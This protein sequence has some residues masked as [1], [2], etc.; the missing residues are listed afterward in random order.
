MKYFTNISTLEQA[1]K[2]YRL[3]AKKYHPDM[4][5]T[6]IEF[7]EMN[8]EYQ[9]LLI[10]LHQKSEAKVNKQNANIQNNDFMNELGRIAKVLVERQVPQ[11]YLKQRIN[12]TNSK[13]KKGILEG[14]VSF[15]NTL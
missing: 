9:K 7:H 11:T 14:I 2:Q 10:Q 13:I 12:T 6:A 3:L 4:G 5:G 1:Q 8:L 15:L